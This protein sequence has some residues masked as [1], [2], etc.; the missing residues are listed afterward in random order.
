MSNYDQKTLGKYIFHWIFLA[1][2]LQCYLTAGSQTIFDPTHFMQDAYLKG[3]A[4]QFLT[5]I[6]SF[7]E[8]YMKCQEVEYC[9]SVNLYPAKSMCELNYASH[10]SHPDNMVY[11]TQHATYF[12]DYSKPLI[13]GKLLWF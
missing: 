3:F 4:Y 8:C 11:G 12:I 13:P 2:L 5:G 9:F 1:V 6:T 10:L 7:L